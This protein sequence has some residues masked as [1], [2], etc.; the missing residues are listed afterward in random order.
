MKEWSLISSGVLQP[1][2][3]IGEDSELLSWQM[4][5][6]K[7]TEEK[8]A[9]NCGQQILVKKKILN[10]IFPVLNCFTSMKS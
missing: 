3:I 10:E 6:A 7:S 1:S 9:N 8:G 4:E 2:G 5:V